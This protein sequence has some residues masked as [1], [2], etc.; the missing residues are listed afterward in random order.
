MNRDKPTTKELTQQNTNQTTKQNLTTYRDEH[1]FVPNRIVGVVGLSGNK[2]QMGQ[3]KPETNQRLIQHVQN[4]REN[5]SFTPE[6]HQQ[7]TK[8]NKEQKRE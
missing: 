7:T 3:K 2:K 6:H 4:T 5:H 1:D 8:H